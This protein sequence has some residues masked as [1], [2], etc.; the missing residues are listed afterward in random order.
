MAIFG[1]DQHEE[2]D[3][4]YGDVHNGRAHIG[5]EVTYRWSLEMMR[6]DDD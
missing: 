5:D 6:A 2:L 3:I 1:N 4:Y